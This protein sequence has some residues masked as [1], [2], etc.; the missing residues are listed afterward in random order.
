MERGCDR[1]I[2]YHISSLFVGYVLSRMI[3]RV[4][5]TVLLSWAASEVVGD[6]FM[7]VLV[8]HLSNRLSAECRFLGDACEFLGAM[9]ALYTHD[10]SRGKCLLHLLLPS[11][12]PSLDDLTSHDV[13]PSIAVLKAVTFFESTTY[14]TQ[15]LSVSDLNEFLPQPN[16]PD[17]SLLSLPNLPLVSP[18]FKS[19]SM[20]EMRTWILN[21]EVKDI[22]GMLKD[23]KKA[24]KEY[25]CSIMVDGWTDGC[26]RVLLNLLVN[27]PAG[28]WFLKS[29]DAFDSIKNGDLMFKYMDEVV[30]E[31]GEENVVQVITDNAKNMINGGK[32][33]MEKREKLYWTPCVAHCLNLMLE[34]IAKLK[35]HA[36]TILKAKQVVKFIYNHSYVLAMMRKHF[37]N[38]K[39]LIRPAMARFATA[40]LTLESIYKQKR[41]LQSMF[42]S[43]MWCTFTYAKMH[44]GIRSR[45]IILFDQDFWPHVPY[46]IKSVVPLVCVLREVDSEE[47]PAMGFLYEMMDSAKEKIAANFYRKEKKYGP[48]W[49]KIDDR[50]TQQLHRP[51]HAAGYYL[52][53]QLH[54]KEN[55]SDCEEVKKGLFKCMDRMLTYEE[56]L[57]ADIQLDLFDNA[58]GDFGT[59]T[60]EL[61][62]LAIRVLSL[63]CNASG[64]ERNWSTFEQIHTKKRNILEDKRLNGLV[65]VKYNTKLRERAIRRR[66]N[67]DPILVSEVASD[68]EWITEKE[69]PILPKDTSWFD[70]ENLLDVDA[71]RALPVVPFEGDDVQATQASGSSHSNLPS[72]RKNSDYC[73]QDKGKRPTLDTIEEDNDVEVGEEFISGRTPIIDDFNED[74]DFDE[75]LDSSL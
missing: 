47:R 4:V 72:K 27:S 75:D 52:N 23:H 33:L 56:R 68:D 39:E 46:V 69:E 67:Y 54:F 73:T 42:S 18:C 28:T 26:S 9:A 5:D 40:F 62:K 22:D 36:S 53:P 49:S 45:L 11:L 61:M 74:E 65:Y 59:K 41:G 13:D 35:I 12:V 19:P 21:D 51:L 15:S 8:V 29:I 20:H 38:N 63:T 2:Q 50:W 58:R 1:G 37:T 30:E 24:S 64:C 14:F 44:D 34:D 57:A 32:K 70:D 25:G 55:F 17:S 60:L 3:E 66:Q 7:V 6:L 10:E 71:I 31:V 43:E 48:I 16:L